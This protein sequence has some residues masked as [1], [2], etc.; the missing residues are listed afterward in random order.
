MLRAGALASGRAACTRAW[1][2]AAGWGVHREGLCIER[3]DPRKYGRREC[4]RPL[5]LLSL[6]VWNL[7]STGM[8]TADGGWFL[9]PA[10]LLTRLCIESEA[11]LDCP[12]PPATPHPRGRIVPRENK[13]L[14][15]DHPRLRAMR[16]PE[17]AGG[18][19]CG[20]LPGVRP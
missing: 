15:P 4:H 17:R 11:L 5:V 10:A 6:S 16:E 7:V 2:R 13:P 1:E 8:L 20:R 18:T 19:V 14:E 9:A 12:T 3:G